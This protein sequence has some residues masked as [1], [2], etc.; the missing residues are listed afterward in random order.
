[1]AILNTGQRVGGYFVQS[2]IKENLYTETY[3]VEDEDHNPY[4]LKTYLTKKMPEKMINQETGI[5]YEIERSQN[6]KHKNLICFIESGSMFHEEGNI[7]Y[8]LTNYLT[9]EV[10]FIMPFSKS[11]DSHKSFPIIPTTRYG[12]L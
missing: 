11:E 12:G 7:Q 5:V 10:R 9:G 8:Y 6:L 1:M 2:L 4:F 3:R